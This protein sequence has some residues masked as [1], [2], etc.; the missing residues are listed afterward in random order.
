VGCSSS[1]G[2]DGRD[3]TKLITGV[4]KQIGYV[5]SALTKLDVSYKLDIFGALCFPNVEGLPWFRKIEIRAILVEGPKPVSRL[6]ARSG[7]LDSDTI[8]RIWTHLGR[9]FPSA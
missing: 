5:S 1:G 6:A 7:P 8:E 3:Q 4:E 2:I 9:E